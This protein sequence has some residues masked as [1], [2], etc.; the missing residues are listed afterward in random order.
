MFD[1]QTSKKNTIGGPFFWPISAQLLLFRPS[2]ALITAPS[3]ASLGRTPWSSTVRSS[4]RA[5]RQVRARAQLL[6]LALKVI[7]SSSVPVGQ[8][9]RQ[10]YGN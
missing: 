10:E 5:A 9:D 4:C 2:Q 3:V 1:D 6:M 8:K 7:T